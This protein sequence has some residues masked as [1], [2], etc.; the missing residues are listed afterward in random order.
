M[1]TIAQKVKR[2]GEEARHAKLAPLT[3][4]KQVSTLIDDIA[5]LAEK[6]SDPPSDEEIRD[7]RQALALV[8][9][10]LDQLRAQVR[11]LTVARDDA[12]RV[13]LEARAYRHG[14][15]D[16]IGMSSHQKLYDARIEARTALDEGE[17]ARKGE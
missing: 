11:A 7:L 8:S 16:I 1:E 12:V 9:A 10:E 2:L 4:I 5:E 14:L 3:P 17:R 13:E 15:L 6:H